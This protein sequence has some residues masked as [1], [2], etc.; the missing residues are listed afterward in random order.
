MTERKC[1]LGETK[2]RREKERK[3]KWLVWNWRIR[4]NEREVNNVCV[5]CEVMLQ[6]CYGVWNFL[7]NKKELCCGIFFFFLRLGRFWTV[8]FGWR[9]FLWW[10]LECSKRKIR[11][12]IFLLLVWKSELFNHS[13][14]LVLLSCPL[15]FAYLHHVFWFRVENDFF[16]D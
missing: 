6:L 4:R 12:F 15:G 10:K 1:V 11:I 13:W 14:L 16:L 7:S 5:V 8:G 2:L 9:V 3:W